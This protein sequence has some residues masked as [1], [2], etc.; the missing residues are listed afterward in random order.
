MRR[1]STHST[2]VTTAPD[3]VVVVWDCVNAA[4]F[5]DPRHL[6][7]GPDDPFA[8]LLRDSAW[9][10]NSVAVAPWTLPSHASM[11]TGLYPW[12]H[13][14]HM[15][16]R[17]SLPR[18]LPSLPEELQRVGYRTGLF[19]FNS[20]LDD[21]G[22]FTRGFDTAAWGTWHEAILRV[23]R[24][25]APH[26]ESST[27]PAPGASKGFVRRISRGLAPALLNSF[28]VTSAVA[29]ELMWKLRP[30]QGA[31]EPLTSPWLEP[32]FGAWVESVPAD[33]PL[34]AF[35]NMGDAHEPYFPARDSGLWNW[36]RRNSIPQ[37]GVTLSEGYRNI[38][39]EQWTVLRHEYARSIARLARRTR[40]L[41]EPIRRRRRYEN[42]CVV[43][44]SDH[45]QGF[46]E[47]GQIFHALRGP[48]ESLL[49]IPLSVHFPG[50][51]RAGTTV[52]EWSSHVDIAP[53]IRKLAGL[54]PDPA[55]PGVPLMD[56]PRERQGRVVL[57]GCDGLAPLRDGAPAGL[58]NRS[59]IVGV[60]YSG[61][62]KV[63]SLH[64]GQEVHVE[65]PWNRDG[66]AV[67]AD[68][69]PTAPPAL[70]EAASYALRGLLATPPPSDP[71]VGV[72]RR[73]TAWGY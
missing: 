43:L 63:I 46:G 2:S 36:M 72:S 6:G 62:C 32:T 7:G 68:G 41:L 70:A 49:R 65:R 25:G 9:F 34:F 13:G 38:A 48:S 64:A 22:G 60:A 51:M 12:Q 18:D 16:G 24:T 28:P 73:L 52:E 39:P 66:T 42:T 8:D 61:E 56:L 67:A 33:T 35:I 45:G 59:G 26:F 30:D 19:A 17:V 44:T 71:A 23:P 5:P 27:L 40:D 47:E 20:L 1:G 54:A 57:A 55:S 69:L 37:D 3:V 58:P 29:N 53:T 4:H 31:D 14:C 10:P 11:L 50:P 21:Q 15:Q